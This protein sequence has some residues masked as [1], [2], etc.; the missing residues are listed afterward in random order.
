[1]DGLVGAHG[2]PTPASRGEGG[3]ATRKRGALRNKVPKRCSETIK[4]GALRNSDAKRGLGA[5]GPQSGACE[6]PRKS[7]HSL[8]A[9][10]LYQ[11]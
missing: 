7:W 4:S 3:E 8:G 1:M 5:T 6:L 11:A 10:P 2:S 9:V